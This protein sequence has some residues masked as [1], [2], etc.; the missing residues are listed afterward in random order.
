MATTSE[1]LYLVDGMSQIF[2]AYYAIRGLSTSQGLAT[3]A[4]YG[5]TTMLRKLVANEQPHYLAVVLDSAEP[6]FRHESF[7]DYKA[8]RGLMPDDL[9]LQLP[10]IEKV[11]DVYG[12]PVIRMPG[13]E[14]DDLIGTLAEEAER[15]GIPTVIVTQDKDLCQLV[16][17][18]ITILREE[19]DRQSTRIDVAGVKERM[20]VE[21]ALV[22]DLL[23]L[24][25]DSS[26]NIPGAPGIG[27]KGAIQ[28]L[29]Q[30]GSIEAAL[31]GWEQVKRKTYRESLRDNAEL[32]R[33]SRELAR[34]KTDCPIEL[35]LDRVRLEEPDATAAYALFSEL[36]FGTLAR[37]YAAAAD[38]TAAAAT[39]APSIARDYRRIASY[40]EVERLA[41]RLFSAGRFAIAAAAGEG[42]ELAGVAL[43]W[44]PGAAVYVDLAAADRPR[45]TFDLVADACGNGLVDVVACDTKATLHALNRHREAIDPSRAKQVASAAAACGAR[46]PWQGGVRIEPIADDVT[47]AAYL[48]DPNRTK[49]PTAELA[50]EYLQIEPDEADDGFEPAA[51]ASLREADLSLRLSAKLGDLVAARGLE[52]VY[53]EIELPLVEA[54]YEIERTGLLVDT[55]ALGAVGAEIE[56]EIARLE[57]E[58]YALAGGE[59]NVNSPTQLAEVFERLNLPMKR[60]TATGKVSTSKDVLEE[61]ASDY[62]LPR[63]VIEYREIAKLKGTYV[64]AL[65]ALIDEATGR[66]HTTLN[67][68]V[69]S[70]GRLS[71]TNP[72]LQNIPVRSATGRAIRRAFVAAPGCVL[73][74]ADYS[75]IELRILAHVA[76]DAAMKTAF[77]KNE[78]IHAATARAVFGAATAAEEKEKRRLAKIVNFAI[79]YSVGAFGLAQR[80]GLSRKEAKAAIENYYETFHGVRRYM[81]ETPERAREGGEVRT[82]FGRLRQI[83]DIDNKNHNLRARAEREAINMPIQGTAADIMKL[84]M[85]AVRDALERDAHSGRVVMQV[86][87][88]LLLEV[89]RASADRTAALVK[90]T[91]ERV[92]ELDVPLVVEVG[93]GQN[94]MEAI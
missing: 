58:I 84:A 62:E 27:E 78:D 48:L 90:A 52:R 41:E 73:V 68:A 88:E 66:I 9:S 86:H 7:A 21:P 40:A 15:R 5:F 31:D 22:V 34:I 18:K 54:L 93:T 37:E 74:S 55:D 94:W 77:K 8:N 85:L 44:A 32:I 63:L 67:Q 29:E 43:A 38:T 33:L 91:M 19:R 60:R 1:T 92:Y 79:A 53:R 2:R 65:P 50:R 17:E 11:C 36:E 24:Q 76:N 16:T 64:D 30:F 42:S 20:G 83:P 69:A 14:A 47:L 25:G 10:Y 56:A 80:T 28:I 59:F 26:D 82:L 89:P 81:D 23:G 46:F 35:D 49:Y 57:S 6:T 61:L 12:V 3:N 51:I 39:K 13:Y 72:N 45:E 71:S 87:D 4:I 75:Q 70:T